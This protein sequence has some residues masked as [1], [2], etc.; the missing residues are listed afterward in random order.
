MRPPNEAFG[1]ADPT[2]WHYLSQPCLEVATA[3]H[4]HLTE[5]LRDQGVEVVFHDESL[6]G[7]SDSI[8]VYDPV[9]VTDF[10]AVILRMGK[11]LRRGEEP[12]LARRL[13]T[14]GIPTLGRIESPGTVEGGD[15]F[16]L[17]SQT[18]AAGI[19]FRT[20]RHGI[21]QL[22]CLLA[23]WGVRVLSFDLPCFQ[24]PEACLHLL[25]LIS[26]VRQDLA[27]GYLPLLPT[28]L[29]Q[30]LSSRGIRCIPVVEEEF[31]S[32]GTNILSLGGGRCLMLA[33]NHRVRAALESEG[34][35]VLT[36]QGKEISL[37]AEGG[38]TCLTLPLHRACEGGW[39]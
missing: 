23:A 15:L 12:A 31:M 18:L 2:R 21:D 5:I 34:C 20:N 36:Y 30:V 25:S 1:S 33:G 32:M 22:T 19:G 4:G 3:E 39:T 35:E 28:A 11:S 26:L 27:V 8:F 17:D 29:W 37:K 10:G 24:G 16:W 13:E 6:P 9:L 14:L 7:L 38:P